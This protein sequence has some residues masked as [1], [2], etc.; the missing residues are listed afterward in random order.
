MEQKADFWAGIWT[1]PVDT[2]EQLT[3]AL[4]ELAQEA[5]EEQLPVLTVE[6]LDQVIN[7][8]S[9]SR[10]MGLDALGPGTI[11]RLPTPARAQLCKLI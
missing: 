7:K 3:K 6:E 2:R 1:D 9:G 10:A 11:R 5:K 4:H 8:M